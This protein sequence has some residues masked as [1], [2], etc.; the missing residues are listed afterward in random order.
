VIGLAFSP[1]GTT[2]FAGGA[3]GTFEVW[4]LRQER[5][6]A[7]HE[8]HRGSITAWAVSQNR[9]SITTGGADGRIR[10]WDTAHG[11]CTQT[12]PLGRRA[13]VAIATRD[14]ASHLGTVDVGGYVRIIPLPCK[15]GGDLLT[16][17]IPPTRNDAAVSVSFSEPRG[18]FAAA[19]PDRIV[20]VWEIQ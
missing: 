13:V 17:R 14:E 8:A 9:R 10:I 20:R 5:R 3:Q 2:L 11:R 1:D 4:D 6:L 7:S 15:D 16:T 12:I 19:G 18:I